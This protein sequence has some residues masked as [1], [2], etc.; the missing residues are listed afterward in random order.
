[1]DSSGPVSRT[2]AAAA[3]SSP[4]PS[5]RRIPPAAMGGRLSQRHAALPGNPPSGLSRRPRHGG[6]ACGGMEEPGTSLSHGTPAENYTETGSDPG[7]QTCCPVD[8]RTAIAARPALSQVPGLARPAKTRGRLPGSPA[9]RRRPIFV[10]LDEKRQTLR[11]R[12]GR[13]LRRGLE[14]DF[15]AVLAAVETPWSNGQV[16]GQINRL[17]TLKR[18]IFGRAGFPLLRARVLPYAPF[19]FTPVSQPP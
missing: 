16:E 10:G 19:D 5:I 6:P 15:S 4:G 18:Q 3:A 8:R 9:M 7:H 1:M 11:D 17:K 2:Q 12:A 13:A 14:K